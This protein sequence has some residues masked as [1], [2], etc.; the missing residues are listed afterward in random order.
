MLS[1]SSD[2]PCLWIFQ[3]LNFVLFVTFLKQHSTVVAERYEI[4]ILLRMNVAIDSRRKNRCLWQSW[5]IKKSLRR[6]FLS[7][8][9]TWLYFRDDNSLA[10][11][12]ERDNL[13]EICFFFLAI[14]H[15][16]RWDLN[17]L[18][19]PSDDWSVGEGIREVVTILSC[20]GIFTWRL[21]DQLIELD[22]LHEGQIVDGDVIWI[23]F[24]TSAT[25]F[26]LVTLFQRFKSTLKQHTQNHH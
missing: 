22:L 7:F 15:A 26:Q 14:E 2:F 24:N 5:L 1:I 12:P 8:L 11:C 18:K 9:L 23:I 13:I 20:R 25:V 3:E 10:E 6:L 16:F 17:V 4:C 19:V 21:L